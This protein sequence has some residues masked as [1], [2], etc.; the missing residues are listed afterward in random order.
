MSRVAAIQM[1]SGPDVA[2]N[3]ETAA[4]LLEQAAAQGAVLAGLPENFAIMGRSEADKLAVSELDGD[5]RSS[6]SRCDR[7]PAPALD[8]RRHD[9]GA[10]RF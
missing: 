1:T 8:H 10:R 9:P 3:L 2:A 6:S 4:R 5:G 7:T